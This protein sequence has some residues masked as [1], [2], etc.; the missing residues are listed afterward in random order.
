LLPQAEAQRSGAHYFTARMR[1]LSS[2]NNVSEGTTSER[3]NAMFRS[4]VKAASLLQCHQ[5][6]EPALA[7]FNRHW[8]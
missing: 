7:G 3:G 8:F 2:S 1:R 4:D 5:Q 6:P